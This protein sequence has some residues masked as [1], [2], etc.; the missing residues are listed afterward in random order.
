MAKPYEMRTYSTVHAMNGLDEVEAGHIYKR[1]TDIKRP[2]QR[3][4]FLDDYG[5]DWDACWAV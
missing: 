5:E 4:V 1:L 2:G 3:I